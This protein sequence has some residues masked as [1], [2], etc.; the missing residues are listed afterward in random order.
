MFNKF[1]IS[2]Y[3]ILQ[4][5][6]LPLF[7]IHLLIRLWTG[8][9]NITSF[10]HRF[11]IFKFTKQINQKLIWFNAASVGESR[12]VLSLITA[13]QKNHKNLNFIITTG[14]KSSA[15]ILQNSLPANT[16]HFF[17]PMDNLLFVKN[18]FRKIKP[19]LGIFIESEL[20]PCLINEGHK[21]CP[22][23]LVN[24][25]LSDRSFIRWQKLRWL[26]NFMIQKFSSI[27]VQSKKDLDKFTTLGCNNAYLAGNIKF[28]NNK[29]DINEQITKPIK[30]ILQDKVIIVAASTHLEDE[31]IL[32]PIIKQL[33]QKNL[34][35]YPIIIQRHPNRASELIKL[36]Q[37]NDLKYSCSSK[38]TLPNLKDHLYIVDSFGQLGNFYEIASI[39]FIG[40]SFTSGGHNLL[41]AAHFNNVIITGPDMSNF[42]N[43]TDD[44]LQENAI[45]QLKNKD[46]F[47][48]K[49]IY[50]INHINDDK[51]KH[52]AIN[53]FNFVNEKRGILD[54]YLSVI[55]KHC[56]LK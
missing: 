12:I 4:F 48:D 13:L 36:C 19:D 32:V 49:L 1:I 50:Y 26:F 15:D 46:E 38:D 51:I 30:N 16:Q 31:K 8:K 35:Y 55:S 2:F 47:A 6:L 24:A 22:L 10:L 3:N 40:G 18:F 21:S 25:R 14:T 45:I 43:I 33:S 39:V 44:M 53:A 27:L 41:E 9:E 28:A 42:Q 37:D 11:A 17:A 5:I 56:G 29:L 20:W 34:N 7:I 52:L 23:L 54:K